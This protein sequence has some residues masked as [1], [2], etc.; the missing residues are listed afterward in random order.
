MQRFI[1]AAALVA[2]LA[3]GGAAH[4]ADKLPA[5]TVI[6]GQVSG[7]TATLLGLDHDFADEAGSHVTTLAAADL[8][9]LSGD[10]AVGIDFFTNGEVQV[11]NNSGAL[12]LPGQYQFTFSFAGLASPLASFQPLDVT[13]MTGGTLSLQVLSDNSIRLTLTD[14]QFATEFGQVSAQLNVSAV[15]E[16]GTLLMMAAG[17]GLVAGLRRARRRA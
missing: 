4:A 2:A 6:T 14:A 16:S 15:P 13:G 9:F 8:E 10:A 17:L 5:G 12:S 7:V 3:A 1:I 11:W